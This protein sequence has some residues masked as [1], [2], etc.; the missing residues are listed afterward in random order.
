MTAKL[1]NSD[2]TITRPDYSLG[3]GFS[4]TKIS[5]DD[6]YADAQQARQVIVG[7]V[8]GTEKKR[9]IAEFAK[10]LKIDLGN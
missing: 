10:E 5:H 2:S 6:D 3:G 7:L 8:N 1:S 4:V 9:P